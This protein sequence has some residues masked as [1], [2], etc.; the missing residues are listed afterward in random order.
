MGPDRGSHATVVLPVGEVVPDHREDRRACTVHLRPRR[1]TALGSD[2]MTAPGGGAVSVVV[3]DVNET[4]SDLEPLRECFTAAGAPGDL[5]DT[6]FASTLRDGFALAAAGAV[7]SFPQVGAGALRYLLAG[8]GGL[9]VPIEEL[10]GSVL[11]G[12][13]TLE[14]HPDVVAGMRAL[15]D[16]GVRLVT[17]T[18]GSAALA[19]RLFDRAGVA[20]LVERRLSVDEAGHWKPHP[21]SYA[22]A[23]QQCGVPLEQMCLVAVHPW[24]TDGAKR[25]G[26]RSGWLN[27]HDAPYPE[28]FVPAD[29]TASTL[30][31]LAAAVLAL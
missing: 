4:L 13:T 16:A 8:R 19:A 24:D 21:A 1:A 25:A 7:A 17:L 29:A 2:H 3:F 22:Y 11:A 23:A 26:M 18:N 31:A 27:R 12:F 9:T 6:W 5:L 14:L 10:V 20:D 30:P 15:A 28:V